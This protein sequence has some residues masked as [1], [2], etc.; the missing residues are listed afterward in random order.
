MRNIKTFFKAVCPL[1]CLLLL[2]GCSDDVAIQK[3]EL[4]A[5]VAQMYLAD[6]YVERTPDMMVQSDTMLLYA[7]I[8]EEHGYTI[9]DY[10]SSLRYYLQDGDS[11]NDILRDAYDMLKKR[12]SELDAVNQ[13]ELAQEMRL[14]V[15]KWWAI[16]SVRRV[17]PVEL[18]HDRLLR[19]L[20]WLAVPNERLQKWTMLDS[21]IVDIPQN[22]QW[23]ANTACPPKR[24][25]HTFMIKETEEKDE[26]NSGKLRIPDNRKP[27]K[28]RLR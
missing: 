24:D 28:K 8:M 20:R 13:S 22:P 21:A 6:Q 15:E 17:A 25:F 19:G 5:I 26:K 9:D 7:G 27:N 12:E 4:S 14:K 2:Q 3:K 1:W 16:D 10:I 11:Y 23:W 18:V